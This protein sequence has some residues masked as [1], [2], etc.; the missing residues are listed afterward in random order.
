ME[1]SL[2]IKLDFM[3]KKSIISILTILFLNSFISC[4]SSNK[5]NNSII[6]N[7]DDFSHQ[8]KEDQRN[9][10]LNTFSNQKN[11]DKVKVIYNDKVYKFEDFKKSIG[12]DNSLN[13]DIIRDPEIISN[14]NLKNCKILLIMN[15]E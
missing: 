9:T 1:R 8:S 5:I 14:Y 3:K 11:I 4:G 6:S 15:S 10:L 2:N 12:F 13:F 7:P